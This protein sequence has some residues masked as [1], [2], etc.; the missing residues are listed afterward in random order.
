MNNIYYTQR[1]ICPA[2]RG[3]QAFLVF[4]AWLVTGDTDA[5]PTSRTKGLVGVGLDRSEWENVKNNKEDQ[6]VKE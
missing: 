6:L 3:K 2:G 5:D 4:V 1:F